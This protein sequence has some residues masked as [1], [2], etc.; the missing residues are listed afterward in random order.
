MLIK[1]PVCPH[2]YRMRVNQALKM[3][4]GCSLYVFENTPGIIY[5]NSQQ[6]LLKGKH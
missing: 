2:R 1:S 6:Y 5:M 4:S 3:T